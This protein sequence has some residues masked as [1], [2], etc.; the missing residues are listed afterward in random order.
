MIRFSSATVAFASIALLV[1]ST[2]HADSYPPPPA[3]PEDISTLQGQLVPVGSQNTYRYSFERWN[4]SANPLGAVF[5][6]YGVSLSYAF[7]PNIALRLDANYFD[8]V[9]ADERGFELGVGIPI[10]FRKV[11]SGLFLEPGMINRYLDDKND[12]SMVIGPQVLIGYHWYW[13]SGLNFAVALGAGRSFATSHGGTF[14][15]YDELFANGY[16]RVGYAF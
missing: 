2:A 8:P 6:F 9:G 12:H 7:H 3:P 4:V 16:L 15:K 11:Y 10:Y 1:V 5:G 13:D 14:D